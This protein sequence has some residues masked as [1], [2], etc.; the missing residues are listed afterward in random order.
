MKSQEVRVD[1]DSIISRLLEVKGSKPGKL[2]TLSEPEITGLCI[3]ARD[4]F[5]GQ[6]MLLELEAPLQI[7]GDIHG[8]FFDLIRIFEYGGYPPKA[9]YLFLGDYVDRGRQ[10]LE[11]IC[12]LL[13]YKVKY[14]ESFYLLRGNHET[15]TIN[16]MYGFYDECKKRY[17]LKLWK[18]FNDCFNCMPVAAL[19]D[20]KILCMHGGL[21]PELKTV[22]DI[23][24]IPRPTE[25]PDNG[26]L[27]DLVW[28]DPD[29]A[30]GGWAENERGVSY[31]FGKE[32]LDAF[33]K[34]NGLDL[35][36]RAHQVVED[37]Y[38]F[39]D[40]KQLVTIFS[41]PN[42]CGEFDNAAGIMQVNENLYC[43]L[44]V[45]KPNEGGSS[46]SRK[47]GEKS[48]KYRKGKD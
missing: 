24:A 42:Y 33:L 4:V 25:I 20:D 45:L 43:S 14:P 21:S 38:E 32:V 19:I 11:T 37:G 15:A 44:L 48:A 5:A 8:Q 34:K 41:A 22:D 39:F 18:V 35:I 16:R 30:I 29:D 13:S 27:C 7:C 40:K 17:S 26:L 31:I 2:V 1:V 9:S 3:E 23:T 6:D 28:S 47:G 12:L 36:V 46:G 10:S